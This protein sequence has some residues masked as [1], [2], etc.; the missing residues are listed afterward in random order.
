MIQ[1]HDLPV[2]HIAAHA[3]RLIPPSLKAGDIRRF[4]QKAVRPWL[5]AKDGE[6]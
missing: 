5:Q 6:V 1:A 3:A 4:W 2:G